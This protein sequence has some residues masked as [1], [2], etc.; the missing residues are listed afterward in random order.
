MYVPPYKPGEA[1]K[2][3]SVSTRRSRLFAGG[4]YF[5]SKLMGQTENNISIQVVVFSPPGAG[6][7]DAV[8]VITNHNIAMSENVIG[9]AK[10]TALKLSLPYNERIEISL[11]SQ[12]Y[13]AEKYS[14]SLQI[15]PPP[16]TVTPVGNFTFSKLFY[17]PNQLSAVLH[18]DTSVSSPSN[19]IIITPR[20]RSYRLLAKEDTTSASWGWDID[21][22]RSQVNADNP[23][24]E[25]PERGTDVQ[26]TQ[27][28]AI[29]LTDFPQTFMSGGDGMPLTPSNENTGP[30][31]S[32]IHVAYAEG[33]D[34]TMQPISQVQEWVGESA[35]LGQWKP[36][37]T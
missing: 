22:L 27:I 21:D 4:T 28:E 30:T 8:C 20:Y 26:D 34:G 23:W 16:P 37:I 6:T 11:S 24:V 10:A 9:P 15:A 17:I 2:L 13:A 33:P 19:K 29:T 5:R 12:P 3:R 32:L 1:A 25:M 18:P 31:K 7:G 14:I 35:S 36:Y